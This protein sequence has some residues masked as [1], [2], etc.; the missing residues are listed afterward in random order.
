MRDHPISRLVILLLVLPALGAAGSG[1]LS[2]FPV[3]RAADPGAPRVTAANL[4]Q[5]ER[6]W[7]YRVTTTAPWEGLAAGARG[8]LIRVRED[9]TARVDF[10]RKGIRRVP[11]DHTDLLAGANE[12]RLGERD[13]MAPNLLLALGSRLVDST[14]DV[15]RALPYSTTAAHGLLLCVFADP[16]A[17]DFETLA[18][19][20]AP[21]RER[22]EVLTVL[23]PQGRQPESAVIERLRALD[24]QVPFVFT[25]LSE[26]YTRTLVVA[27]LAPP[28]VMLQTQEGRVLFE[29]G[30]SPDVVPALSSALE[31]ATARGPVGAPARR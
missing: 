11:V 7:P 10:G 2:D 30:W 23:F 1:G 27:E 24:W 9:G 3:Y 15:P 8:V 21:L 25:H 16:S 29:G 4:L 12:V 5:S 22:G 6:F 26:P 14:G 17:D 31:G 20:L 28:A 18:R 13:K 19:A